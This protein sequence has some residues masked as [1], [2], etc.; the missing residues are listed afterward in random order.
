MGTTPRF[1]TRRGSRGPRGSR[2][3]IP[4]L[5][6]V[7]VAAAIA[8][9][10]GVIN[11]AAAPAKPPLKVTISPTTAVAGST[12]NAFTVKVTAS[13]AQT[14][15]FKLVVPAGWSAPQATTRP[16]PDTW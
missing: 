9:V 7:A 8:A 14:G 13:S 5:A 10:L 11:A 1:T 15:Q 12:N 16:C 2:R 6:L 4:A 3:L